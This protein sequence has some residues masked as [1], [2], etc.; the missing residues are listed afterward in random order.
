MALALAA[1]GC[2][3]SSGSS[4]PSTSSTSPPHEV[5]RAD[6]GAQ[7][8]LTPANGGN[9]YTMAATGFRPSSDITIVLAGPKVATTVA[10]Q[11]P[12]SARVDAQGKFPGSNSASGV[13]VPKGS[14]M[15]TLTV[16][17]SAAS[18]QAVRL[19]VTVEN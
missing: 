17:G 1:G 5:C 13:V 2:G 18:G 12:A 10:G 9:T 7:V 4:A 3:G 15:V 16:T 8:C 6:A 19:A 11:G 14:G